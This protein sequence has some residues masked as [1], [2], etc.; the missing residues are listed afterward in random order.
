MLWEESPALALAAAFAAQ[1]V[2]QPAG[3][4]LLAFEDCLCCSSQL[5]RPPAPAGVALEAVILYLF[6]TYVINNLL[7]CLRRQLLP[8]RWTETR[9]GFAVHWK[10]SI[11][12]AMTVP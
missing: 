12:E 2:S 7:L 5:L 1:T 11:T 4:Q 8:C 9:K 10:A 6:R 3:L